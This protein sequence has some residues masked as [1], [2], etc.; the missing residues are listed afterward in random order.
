LNVAACLTV[1]VEKT[2][3]LS[4]TNF[5][6]WFTKQDWLLQKWSRKWGW[7]G[8]CILW[9]WSSGWNDSICDNAIRWNVNSQAIDFVAGLNLD[10]DSSI[11]NVIVPILTL[12]REVTCTLIY[13][14][15]LLS[16]HSIILM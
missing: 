14:I 4:L 13:H 15:I 6:W 11:Q 2:S 8:R 10:T 9:W 1:K 3:L 7:Y 5:K 16:H 12:S